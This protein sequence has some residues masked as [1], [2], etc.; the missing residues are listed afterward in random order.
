[1][2]AVKFFRLLEIPVGA[3]ANIS[4]FPFPL[5][6]TLQKC[7]KI[8]SIEVFPINKMSVAPSGLPTINPTVFGKSA[9]TLQSVTGEDILIMLPLNRLDT[10]Q[11]NGIAYQVDIAP[12]NLTKCKIRTG[13]GVGVVAGEVFLIGFTYEK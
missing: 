3:N 8:T 13:N 1:M 10:S 4:E 9:V 7:K 5:D 2:Q 6:E 12:L 11:N